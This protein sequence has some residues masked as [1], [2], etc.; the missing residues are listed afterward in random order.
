[1][2]SP[3]MVAICEQCG[4][5]AHPPRILCP[6]C[7]GSAWRLERAGPGVLEEVTRLRRDP[8][9]DGRDG[10]RLAA[11]RLRRGPRVIACVPT[12]VETGDRV[13]LVI[14]DGRASAEPS[15]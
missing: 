1:M 9:S 4:H 3:L 14:L 7:A 12:G 5:A 11:V 13:L 8:E 15:A 2:S 6:V 10:Q